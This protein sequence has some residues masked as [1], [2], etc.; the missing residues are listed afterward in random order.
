MFY[1]CFCLQTLFETF[2]ASVTIL[3]VTLGT[4]SELHVSHHV[5]C[6]LFLFDFNQNI[7]KM[8]SA[9]LEFLRV[10]RLRDRQTDVGEG[11]RHFCKIS[12]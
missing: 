9:V 12:L 6:P 5:N 4:Y 3:R 7:I 8:P 11:K 2:F 10:N 1:F